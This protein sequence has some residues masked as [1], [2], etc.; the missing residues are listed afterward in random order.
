MSQASVRR[1]GA[2]SSVEQGFDRVLDELP[3]LMSTAATQYV[4]LLRRGI[5]L[6]GSFVPAG[7]TDSLSGLSSLAAK[8]N[9]CCTVP[10]QDCPPRCVAEVCWEACLGETQQ[11]SITV[12]NTGSQTRGFSFTATPLGPVQPQVQPANAQ[13]APGQAVAVQVSVPTSEGFKP[14]ETYSGELTIRGAYEQ[15]VQLKLKIAA[16]QTAS[17]TI[18]HGDPSQHITELKWYR[19]WQCTEPCESGRVPPT[20]PPPGS[21]GAVGV[22]G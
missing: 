13:L 15:C 12:K 21:T 4:S 2:S 10:T 22:K 7:L 20:Q 14:G 11:A 16:P 1:L 6:A 19:H 5:D 3:K 9:D 17:V 18:D 8:G